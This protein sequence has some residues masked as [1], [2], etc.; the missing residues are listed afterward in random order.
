MIKQIF[1]LCFILASIVPMN[2]QSF[3][4]KTEEK[5]MSLRADD[6]R[7]I[8][9]EKYLVF[10]LDKV[11]LASFLTQAPMEFSASAGLLM[12]FPMPDG[13][14]ELFEVYESP[15]MQAGISARYPSIKSYKAYGKTSKLKNMRFAV[16]PN[17]FYAAINA[18]DGEK[19]IDPYSEKILMTISFIM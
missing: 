4:K 14:M 17:G 19:Y 2:A 1:S 6:E 12:D 7:T 3:W 9:P 10:S 5:R 13:T 18:P 15:V 8:V 11:G 16:G